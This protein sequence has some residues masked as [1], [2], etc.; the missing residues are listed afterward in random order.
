[1]R[2]AHAEQIEGAV[3]RVVEDGALAMT[4]LAACDSADVLS[5]RERVDWVGATKRSIKGLRIGFSP[6][7]L[8]VFG[9]ATFLISIPKL[10]PDRPRWAYRNA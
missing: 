2:I 6:M 7:Q 10:Q 4:A 9:F 1:L 5:D 3:A 8:E